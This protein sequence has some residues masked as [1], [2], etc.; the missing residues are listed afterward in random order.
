[1]S[2]NVIVSLTNITEL[3]NKIDE[4]AA[5]DSVDVQGIMD[6]VGEIRQEVL[7]LAYNIQTIRNQIKIAGKNLTEAFEKVLE[8]P[9]AKEEELDV[10]G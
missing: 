2:N 4:Y 6:S 3:C 9:K 7:A 10:Y 8:P 1:M 5:K